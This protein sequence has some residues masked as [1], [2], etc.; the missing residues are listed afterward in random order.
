MS[1]HRDEVRVTLDPEQSEPLP[2]SGR[3]QWVSLTMSDRPDR[4]R[5]APPSTHVLAPGQAR[6]LASELLCA[7]ERAERMLTAP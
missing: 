4:V 1:H 6:K 2:R 5:F 7:A 3:L